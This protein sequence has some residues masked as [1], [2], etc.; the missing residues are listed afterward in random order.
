LAL[1]KALRDNPIECWTKA[2]F[3]ERIVVGGFPFGR[4][5]LV[6]DPAAIRKVLVENSADYR[7]SA[8]ERR[9]LSARLRNGLV[10]VEGEQWLSQRRT[11]AP[12]V[13]RKMMTQ[14][15]PALAGAAYL[16]FGVGPRMC[17][18]AAFAL[19]EA[20]LVVATIMKNF[21]FALAP[22]QTV[23]PIQRLTLS[24]GAFRRA[25]FEEPGGA[26]VHRE[27]VSTGCITLFTTY[28]PMLS[29]ISVPTRV[30][31]R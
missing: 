5:V 2:H 31:K 23:W 21:A 8:L 29:P 19:Q 20:T 27:L 24:A 13:G 17:I 28:S 1:L 10:A 30:E 15:A 14:F 16:P 7:K 22:G 9:I 18:G 12:L 26:F 3:E 25:R 6:S 11:L 4:V